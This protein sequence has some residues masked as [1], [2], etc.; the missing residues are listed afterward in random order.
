MAIYEV[1]LN[2]RIYEVEGDSPAVVEQFAASMGG[3]KPPPGQEKDD[4]LWIASDEAAGYG[5]TAA[6]MIGG[7]IAEPIAGLAGIAGTTFGG[8]D[9][10]KGNEWLE[11]TRDALTPYSDD[12][13]VQENMQ[14]IGESTV[15]KALQGFDNATT[16]AADWVYDK[17]GSPITAAAIKAAPDALMEMIPGGALAVSG[18]AVANNVG[19]AGRSAGRAVGRSAGAAETAGDALRRADMERRQYEMA[20]AG[21]DTPDVQPTRGQLSRDVSE[22]AQEDALRKA[23]GGQELQAHFDRQNDAIFNSMSDVEYQ[24]GKVDGDYIPKPGYEVGQGVKKTF[25]QARDNAKAGVD[26]AYTKARKSPEVNNPVA[27]NQ[28][29]ALWNSEEFA[30]FKSFDGS[31]VTHRKLESYM[32]DNGYGEIIDGKLIMKDATIGGLEKLRQRLD[33]FVDSTKPQSRRMVQQFKDKID[34]VLDDADGGDLFKEARAKRRQYSVD[35]DENDFVNRLLGN[36]GKTSR[37]KI[38]DDDVVK[39]VHKLP[40]EELVRVKEQLQGLGGEGGAAWRSLRAGVMADIIDEASNLNNRTSADSAKLRTASFRSKIESMNR[41]GTL[42]VLFGDEAAARLG[43]ISKASGTIN[44]AVDGS[45]NTSN[46][47]SHIVNMVNKVANNAGAIP[48]LGPVAG[49]VMRKGVDALN[50]SA[51]KGAAAQAINGPGMLGGNL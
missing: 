42:T 17:T 18:K 4:G 30:D 16:G 8:G 7:I 47:A 6:S 15:G 36:K 13:Q 10:D 41:S 45:I 46:T 51:N 28:I 31:D 20:Q 11:A 50:V 40:R 37:A 27:T 1:E 2:G 48:V 44:Q 26:A 39:Q 32:V 21:L 19:R 23:D 12:R 38:A 35:F 33:G 34:N 25:A 5:K 29:D 9:A 49:G 14:S 22:V 3:A 24:L 43:Y